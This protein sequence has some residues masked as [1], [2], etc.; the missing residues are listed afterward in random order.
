MLPVTRFDPRHGDALTRIR[1]RACASRTL[2]PRRFERRSRQRARRPSGLSSRVQ[3]AR[4]A[5]RRSQDACNRCLPSIR[6]HE[7]P[8]T[9]PLSTARAN[10]RPM[11][12][13]FHDAHSASE[14][15][16]AL[17]R[18]LSSRAKRPFVLL[19]TS[20]SL[21]RGPRKCSRTLKKRGEP[22]TLRRCFFVKRSASRVRRRL[23]SMAALGLEFYPEVG[24][25]K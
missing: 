7:H 25:P 14:A 20:M 2:T 23:R 22:R 4:A 3:Q 6:F 10:L 15:R 11:P 21:H 1:P 8:H 13:A 18:A 9:M 16:R 5:G 24:W 12:L 17:V 19:L